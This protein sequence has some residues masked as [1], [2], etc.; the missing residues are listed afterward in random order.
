VNS[1]DITANAFFAEGI[2]ANTSGLNSDLHIENTG[3]IAAMADQGAVGIS[4]HAYYQGNAITIEN[5]GD[6]FARANS[7]FS[8]R[9][10]G[11]YADANAD[12]SPVNVVNGGNITVIGNDE[13]V[14]GISIEASDDSPVS[15][16]NSGDI[17]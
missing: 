11:I 2:G 5:Q 6:I 16:V 13:D 3:D 14:T 4:A 15:L 7:S 1:G 12:A 17:A 10:R 8:G 9:A